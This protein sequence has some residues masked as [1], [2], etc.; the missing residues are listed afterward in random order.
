MIKGIND[1][2]YLD[3]V[4][5]LNMDYFDEIQPEIIRGF[6]T[7]RMYAKEG[8]WMKPGFDQSNGSYIWNWKPIYKAIEEFLELPDTDPIKQGGWE[9]WTNSSNGYAERNLFTRYLKM[10]M[11][12]YD[13]YIYY[14]L[15]EEGS[16]DNRTEPRKLTEEAAHF[17]NIVN[18]VE[19]L[20]GTLF[21]HIGR[22]IFFHCD[23]NGMPFE[24]RDLDAKNGVFADNGYTPHRNEFIH[25]RP[26][27]KK[28][29][30]LWDPEKKNKIYLNT[31][32]AW[33]NDQDWHGGEQIMEQSYSLR[34]DGMFTEDFRKK[35]GIDHLENY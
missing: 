21:E 19:S 12:A 1:Q 17:P 14:F 28:A 32:A 2:P 7:A 13:P 20:Q 16:W 31:R 9:L 15:W 10:A 25:I 29:M 27:T 22:V 11:G 34:I 35:L 3:M 26:N 24:H 5:Y 30:Y 6:A 23:H 33:W 18:W 4:P 8:T